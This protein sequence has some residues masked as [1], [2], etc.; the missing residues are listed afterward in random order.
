MFKALLASLSFIFLMNAPN[1]QERMAITQPALLYKSP[2]HLKEFKRTEQCF[3]WLP[4]EEVKNIPT[5]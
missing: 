5:K 2:A 3:V 4:I 1:T